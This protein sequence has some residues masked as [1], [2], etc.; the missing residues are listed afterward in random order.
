MGINI[1]VLEKTVQL[2]KLGQVKCRISKEIKGRILSATI[3]RSPSVKYFVALCCTDVKI[4]P[5]PSTGAA[6]GLDIGIMR[7]RVFWCSLC[8]VGWDTPEPNAR[9]ECIRR[10]H[11]AI[12]AEPIIPRVYPWGV[13]TSRKTPSL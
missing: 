8:M 3:S 4:E 10:N 5:L 1:R 11:G 9:E 2:P 7:A 13:S 6:I 12:L